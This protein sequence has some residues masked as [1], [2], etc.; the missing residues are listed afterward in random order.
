MEIQDSFPS[1]GQIPVNSVG[2]YRLN[3]VSLSYLLFWMDGWTGR[4]Y[5]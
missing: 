2:V 3:L 4:A 5:E 1:S